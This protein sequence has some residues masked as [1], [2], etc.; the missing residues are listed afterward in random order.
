M[1]KC[2]LTTHTSI[3]KYIK[4]NKSDKTDRNISFVLFIFRLFSTS[5]DFGMLSGESFSFLENSHNSF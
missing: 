3:Y 1:N 2:W 4:M 5:F